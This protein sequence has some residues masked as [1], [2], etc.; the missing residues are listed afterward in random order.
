[1]SS[2]IWL[3]LLFRSQSTL[4]LYKMI[5][6]M[7]ARKPLCPVLYVP[8]LFAKGDE[9][10]DCDHSLNT[11]VC[12]AFIHLKCGHVQ[13]NHKWKLVNDVAE[14]YYCPICRS[15]GTVVKLVVGM[16][17]AYYVD[18]GPLTHCFDPCGHVSS[19]KTIE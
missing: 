4:D 7:N 9:P 12:A 18:R 6:E 2:L 16:E 11:C 19:E 14:N 15:E 17:T 3:F 1:M 5:D 10:L 13:G 8:L